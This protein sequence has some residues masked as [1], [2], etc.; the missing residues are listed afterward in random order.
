[1]TRAALATALAACILASPAHAAAGRRVT[2]ALF[3]DSSAEA[4]H[5]AHPQRDGL[6]PQLADEL[7]R[8]GYERGA[9][10]LIP[11]MPRRFKFNAV[12][13][14]DVQRP[15]PGGWA[16]IGTGALPG[17]A[18]PSGYVAYTESPGAT[19][20]APVDGTQLQVLYE[21]VSFSPPF[22]VTAGTASWTIDPSMQPAGPASTWLELPPGTR[23]VTVHGP[24]TPGPFA[25]DGLVVHRP[26]TPDRVQIEV[27]NLA[28][29]GHGPGKDLNP[30]TVAAVRSQAYDVSVLFW[31]PALEVL[32][33]PRPGRPLPPSLLDPLLARARMARESGQCLIV[34]AY[35]L[36]VAGRVVRRVRAAERR[37]AGQAG[38]A[39]T[40]ALDRLWNQR[41]AIRRHNV[42]LDGIHPTARGYAKIARALAPSLAR[43]VATS[44]A[45]AR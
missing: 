24:L 38:C 9:I 35:P 19:A 33:D 14:S 18:G 16:A 43:L 26:P 8:R 29:A 40:S 30:R 44:A 11:A 28:H 12:S 42:V 22:T 2:V 32:G 7:V 1:V 5:L 17:V 13:R 15:A 10:G 23:Q 27:Q 3:G 31:S 4:Y 34:G 20:T 25:F 36:P 39:Y 41:A 21:A 45:A 37:V 6:A